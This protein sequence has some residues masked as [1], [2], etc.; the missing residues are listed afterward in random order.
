MNPTFDFRGHLRNVVPR[1]LLMDFRGPEW[2]LSHDQVV[3]VCVAGFFF[4]VWFFWEF[5]DDRRYNVPKGSLG[6]IPFFG[7]T[8]EFARNP[9]D[10]TARRFK[11]YGPVF[12]GCFLGLRSVVSMDPE[13]SQLRDVNGAECFKITLPRNLRAMIGDTYN[14]SA[15][16]AGLQKVLLGVMQPETLKSQIKE[17]EALILAGLSQWEGKTIGV[18]RSCKKIVLSISVYVN[19]GHD[20]SEKK[21]RDQ[22]SKLVPI[23]NEALVA[24]PLY[25]PGTLYYRG[26]QA[27]LK[28]ESLLG[29]MVK[30]RRQS[31]SENILLT[32]KDLLSALLRYKTTEGK[33][34]S[35]KQI[36]D[37]ICISFLGGQDTSTA[38]LSCT[39]KEL[40]K[41]ALIRKAVVAECDAIEERR[42][43]STSLTMADTRNMLYIKKLFKEVLRKHT[44][45][46]FTQRQAK[47]DVDINGSLIPRGWY[48]IAMLS[49]INM[50]PK[51]WTNPEVFNPSRFDEPQQAKVFAPFGVGAHM[52]PAKALAELISSIFVY[53]L[54][55]KYEWKVEG[56]LVDEKLK[57]GA[58]LPIP[59]PKE[60][61]RLLVR[62]RKMIAKKQMTPPS[63]FVPTHR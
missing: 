17:I 5:Y 14:M 3:G 59:V 7:E 12:K 35:L 50:N 45:V 62:R 24:P 54:L 6:W 61:I 18:W 19:L 36:T 39:I 46:P 22:I 4:L 56:K 11:K 13:F 1:F 43:A 63:T 20:P 8:L 47:E 15:E 44:I 34:L 42:F 58:L 32:S 27:R 9:R 31:W 29:Q 26:Y 28:M 49:S 41:S 48:A 53:H 51:L 52:C 55:H 60:E 37:V 40:S 16:Q 25:L 10:Y 21:I 38:A 33:E 2:Q 57:T 23:F 30:R